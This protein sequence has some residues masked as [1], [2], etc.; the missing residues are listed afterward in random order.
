MNNSVEKILKKNYQ[1]RLNEERSA[2]GLFSTVGV[3]EGLKS[4][5]ILP[6][7][8]LFYGNDKCPPRLNILMDQIKRINDMEN[9]AF[10]FGGN[11]FYYPAGNT[12]KKEDLALRYISDLSVLFRQA[13]KN[14]ILFLYNGVNETKFLDDRKLSRPIET[15]KIIADNLGISNRFFNDTKVEIGFKFNNSLT[16]DEDR[17]LTAFFTSTAPISATTN[18][19]AAK[20]VKSST[21]NIAKDLIVDTSSGRFYSKKRVLTLSNPKDPLLSENSEQTLLSPAGY[22]DMPQVAKS[23]QTQLYPINNRYIELK[24]EPKNPNLHQDSIRKTNTI[25]DDPFDRN[26]VCLTFGVNYDSLIDLNLV[27]KLNDT[28]LENVI[29]QE[30]LEKHVIEALHNDLHQE[31]RSIRETYNTPE[32]TK[33]SPL[34]Y[35]SFE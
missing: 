2:K 34:T 17:F 8:N 7:Q 27:Q 19:I 3:P 10:I 33:M 1:N 21:S 11:L 23:K 20:T 9:G 26:A 31:E 5:R 12:D 25:K 6:I 22:T 24:I 4:L 28:L 15:T 18:A 13:D 35:F 32:S 14:K 16:K 29:K 30:Q